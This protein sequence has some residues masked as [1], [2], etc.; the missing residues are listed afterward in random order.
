MSV[1]LAGVLLHCA[2]SA[3]KKVSYE[4]SERFEAITGTDKT[5]VTRTIEFTVGRK[6]VESL[7][8]VS[9]RDS[10]IK[11]EFN[12]A[13]VMTGD[14]DDFKVFNL[15]R[16]SRG[17]VFDRP[18]NKEFP[19]LMARQSRIVDLV[20]AGREVEVGEAWT[21]SVPADPRTSLPRCS[22]S[23]RLV[24]TDEKTAEIQSDF[25]ETE[26]DRPMT[27]TA[28]FRVNRADGWIESLEAKIGPTV[29]PG[30]EEETPVTL[31]YTWKRK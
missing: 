15:R 4:V 30:D 21:L 16:D 8:P 13:D 11:I 29:V 5:T 26:C 3:G 9:A 23:W 1:A 24:A 2:L 18:F 22:W 14:A 12:G 20:Y 27:G 31:T 19:V 25:A 28:R 6:P 17:H 7:W 10:L